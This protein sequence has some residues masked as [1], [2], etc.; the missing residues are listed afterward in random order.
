MDI[1][2]LL[3]LQNF[4]EGAGGIFTAFFKKMT[5]WGELNTVILLM[6]VL[7]WCIDKEL[8]TYVMMG[9]SGN[10][11]V[12]GAMK[13]T[14]CAYRPWIRSAKILPEASARTTA[15]GYSF[16]SGHTM[17]AASVYGGFVVRPDMPKAFRI[18]CGILVALVAL[19][20][21]FLGVHT[22]Q[23]VL[24]GAAAGLLVMLL[25]Y[26]LH[27]WICRHPEKITLVVCAGLV[28]AAAI[29]LY[30]G[31][32]PYPTDYDA[33]GKL[34]VDGAVMARDTFKG[35]GWTMGFLAGWYLEHRFVG[36]T[37]RINGR[38]R[39]NRL[40]AGFMTFYLVSQVLVPMVS[41][42]LPGFSG[43]LV[44]CFLQML[45]ITFLFPL[46]ARFFEN[47]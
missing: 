27:D 22:P 21:N 31:L 46:L 17:N 44:S 1:Q 25:T 45:Y 7:Y 4:R 34:L 33:D 41:G 36:F 14:V 47:A 28:L 42:A 13:V 10:R 11:L 24:I 40:A 6:A 12:N 20:R 19:S 30:A 23:D 39:L 38:Q 35:A 8:G 18:L 29:C 37:T 32:K 2:I 5:F 3:F 16:P 9:W 15:T 43:P 26:F